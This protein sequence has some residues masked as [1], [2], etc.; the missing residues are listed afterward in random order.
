[1]ALT[2]RSILL[3]LPLILQAYAQKTRILAIGD[4]ITAIWC[5]YRGYLWQKLDAAGLAANIDF[6]GSQNGGCTFTFDADHEAVGGSSAI[7]GA[8]AGSMRTWMAND[9]PDIVLMH[10]GTNDM[11]AGYPTPDPVLNAY[12]TLLSQ[13]REYNPNIKWVVA[14]IIPMAC[15]DSRVQQLDAAIPAWAANN[16]KPNSPIYVVDCHTGF[17]VTADT[18]DGTHPN[19]GG[20]QKMAN[21]FYPGVLKALGSSTPATTT[22][23][24][25]T[26]TTTLLTTTTTRPSTTTTTTRPSTTTTTRST[27]TTTRTTITTAAPS[28]TSGS[29]TNSKWAQCDGQGFAG[30]KCCPA[31]TTCKFSNAWYSQCL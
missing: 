24:R 11:N 17:D 18:A 21:A 30:P 26:T 8:N 4:S 22:G 28:P 9:K 3:L 6:V 16:T 14:Q 19:T 25:T 5:S 20:A 13:S 2:M 31:G 10:W 27:T 29:C 23:V 12:T 15:C 7:Q 1:M